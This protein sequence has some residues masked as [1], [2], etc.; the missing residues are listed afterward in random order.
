MTLHGNVLI[1]DDHPLFRMA[2]KQAV[3]QAFPGARVRHHLQFVG[4]RR[5]ELRPDRRAHVRPGAAHAGG[6]DEREWR[7]EDCGAKEATAALTPE[8]RADAIA[9]AKD[10]AAADAERREAAGALQQL[11]ASR[12]A[13][14]ES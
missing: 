4:L 8:E 13:E 9:K 12:L 2:L 1:A 11:L 3:T 14:V 10:Q 5:A 7:C 6:D